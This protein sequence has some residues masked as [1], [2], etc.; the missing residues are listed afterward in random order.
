M[1]AIW[2][3]DTITESVGIFAIEKLCMCGDIQT[4]PKAKLATIK[5]DEKIALAARMPVVV[6]IA[7]GRTLI[8]LD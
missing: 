6:A 3:E 4:L 1:V 5:R 8:G 7:G 2:Q